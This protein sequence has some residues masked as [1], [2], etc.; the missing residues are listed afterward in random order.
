MTEQWT[1][2]GNLNYDRS[3]HTATVLA[4]G[5]VLVVGGNNSNAEIYDPSTGRWTLTGS[6]NEARLQH[7]ATILKNGKVLIICGFGQTVEYP[8]TTEVYDPSTHKW[9]ITSDGLV[10]GLFLEAALLHDGRVLVAGGEFLDPEQMLHS[11]TNAAYIYDP[12]T[13]NWT[14]IS[15]MHT[16]RS[17]HTLTVLNDGKALVA[18]GID[19]YATNSAELYDPTKT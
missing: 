5:R 11:S 14:T 13:S 6:L 15:C 3:Y 18:G 4:D 10:A 12:S 16:F 17:Q 2:T 9:T 19:T 7:A 1:E 8:T